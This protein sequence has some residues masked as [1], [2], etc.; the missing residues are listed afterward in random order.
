MRKKIELV[1]LNKENERILEDNENIF[2]LQVDG[3]KKLATENLIPGNQVYN[4]K[5]IKVKGIEYRTWDPFRSKLAASIFNGLNNFPFK[6]K[7][8]ILY[9]GVSTGTT[10]SHIS[11]IVGNTGTIFGVE[12]ASRVARDFLDRVASHRTNIV[13]II[14][15]ARKP[16]E[17]FSVSKKVDIVYVDIAQPDQTNIAIGN[18]N[19]YL[20]PNG[21]LFLVIKSRSIDVT[22]DPKKIFENEIK[23]LEKSFEIKQ[24]INLGPYDKDHAIVIATFLG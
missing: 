23:K 8:D 2:W 10:V 24:V 12:H 16:N 18:C 17:Y 20:K 22:K 9:L 19:M 15:D 6:L 5:L 4:E 1:D 7:S 13:P 11:D 3:E 21:Y 14:Q